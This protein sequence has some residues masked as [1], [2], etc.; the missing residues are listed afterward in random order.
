[1]GDK[2]LSIVQIAGIEA[3]RRGT[4]VGTEL[5]RMENDLRVKRELMESKLDPARREAEKAATSSMK[6]GVKKTNY[7]YVEPPRSKP[8]L[9]KEG[10][11]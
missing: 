9:M 6:D 4:D 1:M 2:G 11:S 10:Q 5:M 3:Q 8:A 7:P